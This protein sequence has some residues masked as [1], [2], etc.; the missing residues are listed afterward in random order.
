M[1]DLAMLISG[2]NFQDLDIGIDM[3][4]D[5]TM[6]KDMNVDMDIDIDRTRIQKPPR[7]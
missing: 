3:D 1:C 7:T 4:T 2:D 5:I 6:D